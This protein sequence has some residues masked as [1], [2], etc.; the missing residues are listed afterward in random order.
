MERVSAVYS[1]TEA[2]TVKVEGVDGEAG[3]LV[4]D[5]LNAQSQG[6]G[7]AYG[8]ESTSKNSVGWFFFVS[9]SWANPTVSGKTQTPLEKNEMFLNF[10]ICV[11][12]DPRE[13]R[14]KEGR[15]PLTG[16]RYEVPGALMDA[17]CNAL[18]FSSDSD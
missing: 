1:L 15:H 2:C 5:S 12:W 9:L 14:H 8:Q 18:K 3:A 13:A 7:W 4:C 17:C 11:G 6:S 16:C 10:L